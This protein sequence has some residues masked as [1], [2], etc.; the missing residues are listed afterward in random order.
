M[1]AAMTT[2]SC[3]WRVGGGGG[4]DSVPLLLLPLLLRVQG[5]NSSPTPLLS[6]DDNNQNVP[7]IPSVAEFLQVARISGSVYAVRTSL[8][9]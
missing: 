9:F 2:L 7:T 5:A 6:L 4:G 1:V 3:W 8:S